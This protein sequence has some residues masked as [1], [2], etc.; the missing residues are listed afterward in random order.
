IIYNITLCILTLRS[1]RHFCVIPSSRS[2]VARAGVELIHEKSTLTSQA[3]ET[4]LVSVS[5]GVARGARGDEGAGVFGTNSSSRWYLSTGQ[6]AEIGK[7]WEFDSS[8][9]S[10]VT[11]TESV[12]SMGGTTSLTIA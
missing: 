2:F 10:F 11:L 3:L 7:D 8:T 1:Y 12:S 4:S 5:S 6:L 9:K